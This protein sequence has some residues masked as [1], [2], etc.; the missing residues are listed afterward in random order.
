MKRILIATFL[1]YI[2]GS[3]YLEAQSGDNVALIKA[4]EVS[5]GNSKVFL[6]RPNNDS[7]IIT[8]DALI[9]NSAIVFKDQNDIMDIDFGQYYNINDLRYF[10]FKKRLYILFFITESNKNYSTLYSFDY[11]SLMCG[12][13][14]RISKKTKWKHFKCCNT[15]I[16]YKFE[17][18][19]LS[20]NYANDTIRV[21]IL[22]DLKHNDNPDLE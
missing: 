11:A 17:N 5:Q 1:I 2:I 22:K 12:D 15:L 14:N 10:M 20:L 7:I 18:E 16:D 6:I 21:N 9:Y 8:S 19:V 3:F 13:R 4:N